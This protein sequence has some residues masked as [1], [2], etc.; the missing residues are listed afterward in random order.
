[1]TGAPSVTINDNTTND[2]T[3]ALTGTIDDPEA[4]IVVT[5]EGVDYAATNN[6]DG[7]WTLVDD[8]LPALMDGSYQ[9]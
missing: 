7:T 2:S 9:G 1:D 5:V 6:G 4:S 8:T 3:P